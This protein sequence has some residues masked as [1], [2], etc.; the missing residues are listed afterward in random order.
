[1]AEIQIS[2]EEEDGYSDILEI[3]RTS[4]DGR[5]SWNFPVDAFCFG[6]GLFVPQRI[7]DPNKI[8]LKGIGASLTACFMPV[9]LASQSRRSS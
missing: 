8:P 5:E 1:M 9:S 3:A 6:T 7:A 4:C 2:M